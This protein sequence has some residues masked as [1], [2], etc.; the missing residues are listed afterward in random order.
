MN[1]IKYFIQAFQDF[2]QVTLDLI[3]IRFR[4][5]SNLIH[6]TG[7]FVI[8]RGIGPNSLRFIALN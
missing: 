2:I 3:L 4:I 8:N 5:F 7:D 6:R 1:L